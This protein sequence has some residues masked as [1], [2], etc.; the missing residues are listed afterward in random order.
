MNVPNI[1]N[2]NIDVPVEFKASDDYNLYLFNFTYKVVHQM[3]YTVQDDGTRMYNYN[4]FPIQEI[5]GG[6]AFYDM[7]WKVFEMPVQERYADYVAEKEIL[8]NGD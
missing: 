1:I 4:T 3:G 5:N 2:I 7:G 6:L 8:N